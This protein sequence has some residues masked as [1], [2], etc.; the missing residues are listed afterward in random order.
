MRSIVFAVYDDNGSLISRRIGSV[1]L[2]KYHVLAF[3]TFNVIL[4]PLMSILISVDAA[5]QSCVAEMKAVCVSV[6]MVYCNPENSV[7]RSRPSG[8]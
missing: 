6:W 8:L 7:I 1:V 2:H 4:G 5:E 3:V